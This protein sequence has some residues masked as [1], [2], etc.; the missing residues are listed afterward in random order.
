LWKG[1]YNVGEYQ[2]WSV[3]GTGPDHAKTSWHV[4]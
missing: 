4:P 2:S 1:C 3:L